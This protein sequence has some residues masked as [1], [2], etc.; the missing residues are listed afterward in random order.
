MRVKETAK[1]QKAKS[2]GR[3]RGLSSLIDHAFGLFDW[4]DQKYNNIL[5]SPFSEFLTR[6][7]A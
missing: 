5:A 2:A 1:A 4:C 3:A 6:L 7:L